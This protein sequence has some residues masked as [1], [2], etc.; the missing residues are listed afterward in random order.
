MKAWILERHGSAESHPLRLIERDRPTPAA[1]ELLVEVTC[2]G[3]CRTDLHLVEGDIHPPS[4]PVIPGH[5]AVGRVIARGDSCRSVAI[6]ERV[7]VAW[8]RSTCSSCE[9]CSTARENLCPASTYTG[10]HSNGGYAEYLTVPEEYVYRVPEGYADFEAAPLLC[11]GIIGFRALKRSALPNGGR[12]G[13]FGFGSSAHI[14][15]QAARSITDRI[16]VISRGEEH[17][18]H[19][20]SLGA[21]WVGSPSETFPEP[22]DSVIL[23]APAGELFPVAL[24]ALKPGGTAVSAGI[25]MSPIPS[26]DYNECLFHERQMTSVESNTRE[27]GRELFALAKRSNIKP[28]VTEY[29]FDAASDVLAMLKADKINGTAVLRIR[30]E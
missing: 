14:T 26:F 15:I 20:R 24:R 25:Y 9:Y 1:N 6:G 3:V 22:L 28:A 11:A 17:R 7:G 2:C 29:P 16:F 4:L 27:D 12:L 18:A 21:T 30:S 19:A 5:Q 8:L 13:I 10:F 23:F